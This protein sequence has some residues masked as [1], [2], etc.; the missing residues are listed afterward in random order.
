MIIDAVYHERNKGERPT[1][2]ELKLKKSQAF[3]RLCDWPV[4]MRATTSWSRVVVYSLTNP[5]DNQLANQNEGSKRSTA[6]RPQR[7]RQELKTD[8]F[9]R[10]HTPVD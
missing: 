6:I 7:Y 1:K 3:V 5:Y 2:I 10:L 8:P 9:F 4:R